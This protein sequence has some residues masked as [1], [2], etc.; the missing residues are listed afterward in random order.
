MSG[1][2]CLLLLLTDGFSFPN[3]A[4][5]AERTVTPFET[6][7]TTFQVALKSSI[8]RGQ[9]KSPPCPGGGEVGGGYI[10]R[11]HGMPCV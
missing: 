1:K 5:D 10:P 9:S 6:K 7:T 2:A 11:A 4:A 8:H 3:R